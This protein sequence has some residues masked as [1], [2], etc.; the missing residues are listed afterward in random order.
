VSPILYFQ[1]TYLITFTILAGFFAI[2]L[3]IYFYVHQGGE[4]N[5]NIK[6]AKRKLFL[7]YVDIQR[8]SRRLV[9]NKITF[10]RFLFPPHILLYVFLFWVPD[11]FPSFFAQLSISKDILI[12][13]S[14]V[15]YIGIY[16][17]LHQKFCPS[18]R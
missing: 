4:R 5:I 13:L 18:F 9:E 2:C 7:L 6:R 10:I 17:S 16:F 11:I 1:N 12:S 15:L 14:L 3:S 8:L